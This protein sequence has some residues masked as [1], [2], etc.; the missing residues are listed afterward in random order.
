MLSTLSSALAGAHDCNFPMHSIGYCTFQN[1]GCHV[2]R[3]SLGVMYVC[4]I[5]HRPQSYITSDS[6]PSH[7]CLLYARSLESVVLVI[8]RVDVDVTYAGLSLGLRSTWKPHAIASD[9]IIII[10]EKLGPNG[11][12]SYSTYARAG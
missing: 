1:H 11:S 12:K 10:R 9:I 5:L 6:A 2:A 7:M 3:S 8:C 4:R